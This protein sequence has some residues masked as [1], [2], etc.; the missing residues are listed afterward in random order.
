MDQAATSSI[1]PLHLPRHFQGS[2]DG[3]PWVREFL[4]HEL[5]RYFEHRGL[6][7]WIGS[8]VMIV[9][10]EV[11]LHADVAVTIGADPRA[12]RVWVSETEGRS[13]D[14]AFRIVSGR[15]RLGALTSAARHVE[16]GAAEGFAFHPAEATLW[17][18]HRPHHLIDAMP[19]GRGGALRSRALGAD[20]LPLHGRV[21]LM[22][23]GAELAVTLERLER[24]V[25]RAAP[26]GASA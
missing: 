6:S 20:I 7:A 25:Q 19:L 18:F 9:Q 23:A 16:L 2:A 13:I 3:G 15:S 5:Q 8:D 21:R 10:R 24:A 4:R 14:V 12:R 11:A 1:T 26:Q 22:Q 17:G